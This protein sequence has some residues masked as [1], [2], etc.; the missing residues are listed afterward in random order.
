MIE[1]ERE[2]SSL[3][4][5]LDFVATS[6]NNHGTYLLYH[7][8][9]ANEEDLPLYLDWQSSVPHHHTFCQQPRMQ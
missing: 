9:A 8:K 6:A 3:D 1:R 4:S 2:S 7:M 5:H